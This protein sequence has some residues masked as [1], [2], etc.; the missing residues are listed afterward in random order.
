[1]SITARPSAALSWKD[2]LFA[3]V[4]VAVAAVVLGGSQFLIGPNTT[5][6]GYLTILFLLSVVRATSWHARLISV[7]W[8]LG[9]AILGFFIGGLGLWATLVA[10]VVVSLVQAFVTMGESVM[11]TRSP[12]NLLAFA[13]LGQSGAEIWQILLGAT[14]GTAV[15]LAFAAL[16][17][18][19]DVG[20]G[21]SASTRQ[22]LAYGAATSAGALIIVVGAEATGFPFVG[23]A[24]LSFCVILSVGTDQRASRG[25]L[26][27]AGSVTGALLAVLLSALPAP[28]PMI[29]AVVCIV[30]CVAYVNS[31]NYV[32]F[33]L[34]M[35]PAVLLT[36][37]SEHSTLVLG[38]LRLESVLVA[39]VIA[40]ICSFVMDRV[41]ARHGR[42]EGSAR[43]HRGG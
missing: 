37:A 6:S 5:I 3:V 12:V 11:L 36:T 21:A 16:T 31:G 42:R 25:Y 10:L 14:I 35:T 38:F 2:L 19:R 32:L 43:A 24:L 13:T 7:A 41:L 33:V 40:L 26:R 22:R 29:A 39:T 17:N 20:H 18:S 27:I 1:M 34:F 9:V 30:L 4:L 28:V 15:I 8:S 23:W